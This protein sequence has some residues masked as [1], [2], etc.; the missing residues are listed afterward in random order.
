MRAVVVGG[1]G[2][3][4]SFL[5]ER[6][7][8]E[9][10]VV[11]VVDDLSSGSLANL[12]TARSEA[13]GEMRFHHMDVRSEA[14][15]DLI[16]QRQPDVIFVLVDLAGDD[17]RSIELL[18]S[19]TLNVIEAAEKCSVGKIV[20]T[21]DAM[22]LHGRVAASELPVK[23]TRPFAPDSLRGVAMRTM[24]DLLALARKRSGVEF[25]LLSLTDVYGPRQRADR[26][27]VAAFFEA[28]S[29]AVPA[30]LPGDGRQTRDFVYIDDVVDAIAR[31][32][33]RGGGLVINV[34]TGVQTPLRAVERLVMTESAPAPGRVAQPDQDGTRFAVSPVRARI[35]LAWAPWTE[36]ADGI[37]AMRTR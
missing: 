17:R 15:V 25:T 16:E 22:A 1:A 5:V 31:A 9:R 35:H 3:I 12:A 14:F 27:V 23:D 29:A 7:L 24:V 19:A 4:G 2:F 34:G 18:V 6:L 36:L 28:H 21:V 10:A 37:E 26:S 30:P 8:A 32:A 33:S 11:D 20:A 13:L